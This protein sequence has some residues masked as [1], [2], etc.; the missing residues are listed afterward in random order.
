[1]ASNA[2]PPAP[3]FS[4]VRRLSVPG[5]LLSRDETGTLGDTTL[6]EWATAVISRT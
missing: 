6:A 4:S 1:M 2:A 5:T 3:A